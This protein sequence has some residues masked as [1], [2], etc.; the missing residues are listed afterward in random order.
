MFDIF[1]VVSKEMWKWCPFH[2]GS[3]VCQL[4]TD[5]DE[6]V[7]I[8]AINEYGAY[9]IVVEDA[10]DKEN[11]T[12]CNFTISSNA[13]RGG[14]VFRSTATAGKYMEHVTVTWIQ[15]SKTPQLKYMN[16]PS[17]EDIPT[18]QR[19]KVSFRKTA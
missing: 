14:S 15:G 18:I 12:V 6:G 4:N 2:F 19:F 17:G 16:K 3:Q 1:S 9:N 7:P 11:G 10:D 5:S 13:I 8:D